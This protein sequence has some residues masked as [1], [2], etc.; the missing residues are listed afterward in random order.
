MLQRTEGLESAANGSYAVYGRCDG[1]GA[2]WTFLGS[3]DT[4]WSPYGPRLPSRPHAMRTGLPRRVDLRPPWPWVV[5][6]GVTA[7]LVAAA[8]A[9]SAAAPYA[10]HARTRLLAGTSCL[11]LAAAFAVAAVGYESDGRRREAMG[12]MTNVGGCLLAAAALSAPERTL[13]AVLFAGA[14]AFGG[15]RVA[16][17]CLVCADGAGLY[18][19][20]PIAAAAAAVV[21][22][23]WLWR[24]G[25]AEHR[26][27][28]LDAAADAAAFHAEWQRLLLGSAPALAAVEAAASSLARRN[29]AAAAVPPRHCPAR[30]GHAPLATANDARAHSNAAG[31]SKY[32]AE[33]GR[34]TEG[35]VC[36]Q[37]TRACAE[38]ELAGRS[39]PG[40]APACSL[41]QLYTQA[42]V[43]APRLHA[44]CATIAG[45]GRGFV[46]DATPRGRPSDR[47]AEGETIAQRC[48]SLM[49]GDTALLPAELR[50]WVRRG[51]VKPPRR[52]AEK[53]VWCYDGDVGRVTDVC[54]CRAVLPGPEGL[55]AV[56]AALGGMETEVAVV[57]VRNGLWVD[58]AAA[59]GFR[60]RSHGNLLKRKRNLTFLSLRAYAQW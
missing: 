29:N 39:G 25:R 20:P 41:D 59:S 31:G 13:P 9:A 42:A 43:V 40:A 52:A 56:L 36:V 54:R 21:L 50:R 2:G 45:A 44:L 4:H 51:V 55:A 53:A 28:D 33:S 19:D 24:S 26:R 37:V 14:V 22:S 8:A 35:G 30:R 60:V 23:A 48:S 5:E 32:P 38:T 27:S 49:E 34:C 11:L 6:H 57:H 58:S 17:Y 10:R 1:H 7:L 15:G 18:A 12:S 47:P 3:S 16:Y 46:D